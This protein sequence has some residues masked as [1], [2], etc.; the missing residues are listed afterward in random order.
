MYKFTRCEWLLDLYRECLQEEPM[1]IPRKFKNDKTYVTSQEELN[2]FRKNDLSNLQSECEILKLKK[3]NLLEN[4]AIQDKILEE[5]L[6]ERKIK[7]QIKKEIL[8]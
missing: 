4:I 7:Q 6:R 3:N 8:L 2:V 5:K 1:Y